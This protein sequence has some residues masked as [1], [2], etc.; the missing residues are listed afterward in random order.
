[1]RRSEADWTTLDP[2]APSYAALRRK[3]PERVIRGRNRTK[4]DILVYRAGS[5]PLAVKDYAARPWWIRQTVGRWLTRRECAA[6]RSLSGIEALPRFFGRLGPWTLAT[7]LVP[8]RPLAERP[9]AASEPAVFDRL[10]AALAEIHARGVALGDLHHRDV[11][12]G[13]RGQ[14]WIVDLAT[15]VRSPWLIERLQA[16]DRNAA[17]RLRQRHAGTAGPG[18]MSMDEDAAAWHRRARRIKRIWDR[19][20]GRGNAA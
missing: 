13:E 9:P 10:D 14:L 6:Y 5:V 3:A 2:T 4:A 18:A 19:L 17:L 11:L 20:R 7:E 16:A 12:L 8:G 1:M 15:A